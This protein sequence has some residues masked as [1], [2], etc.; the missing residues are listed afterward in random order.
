MSD[1]EATLELSER[2][3]GVCS[4]SDGEQSLEACQEESL[5]QNQGEE[6]KVGA[7][8]EGKPEEKRVA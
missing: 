4:D 1:V 5:S 2:I 8:R 7:S 3:P 6:G